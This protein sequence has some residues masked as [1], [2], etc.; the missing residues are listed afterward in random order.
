MKT[1][2]KNLKDNEHTEW[3]GLYWT[4]RGLRLCSMF[5]NAGMYYCTQ[6]LETF[7]N[8]TFIDV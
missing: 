7:H 6:R 4:C 1:Q 3:E 5:L 2:I 8:L